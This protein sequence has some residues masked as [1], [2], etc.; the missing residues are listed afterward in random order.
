M[1][2]TKYKKMTFLEERIDELEKV[3]DR[4]LRDYLEECSKQWFK[5]KKI[6]ELKKEVKKLNK[7]LQKIKKDK[8]EH[9]NDT[10]IKNK[11]NYYKE[12]KEE[13]LTFQWR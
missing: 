5:T 10:E 11:E 9:K 13:Q 8:E 12:P 6:E 7:A 2:L 4:L 1:F 3:N